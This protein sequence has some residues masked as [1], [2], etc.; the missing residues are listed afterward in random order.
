M[1]A[2]A[3]T[4]TVK[5]IPI[6]LIRPGSQQAR[7]VFNADALAELAESIKE[8][9]IVQPLV[10]RTRVWGYEIL[11][12]ERRWR[13]AQMASVHNVPAIIRD[14]LSEDEAFVLGLIENLQRESLSPIEAAAGLKRL[15]ELHEL[16]HEEIAARIG[17]SRVYVTHILRLLHLEPAVQTLVDEGHLSLG[18]A[19]ALS[20]L[21]LQEQALWA[22]AV[23]RKGLTVRSLEKQL[24]RERQGK[25]G[26]KPAKPG[27]WRRLERELADLLATPVQVSANKAGKGDL[28]L[29]FHSL[30][31]L[32]GLLARLGYRSS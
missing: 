9:G 6:D 1:H 8:S 12:G 28:K 29:A 16:T 27:D 18:H 14:D 26:F 25:A 23:V 4:P 15:A 22:T 30:D 32:D 13:A 11:A 21:P 3:S 7:K 31:E 17:K 19:K 10:L 5:N 20:G 2:A 24:S